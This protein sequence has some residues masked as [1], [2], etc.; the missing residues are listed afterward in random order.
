MEYTSRALAVEHLA[1]VIPGLDREAWER[2]AVHAPEWTDHDVSDPGVT[3]VEML[4]FVTESLLYRSAEPAAFPHTAESAGP[5][6]GLLD[7]IAREIALIHDEMEKLYGSQF[8]GT[9]GD[10]ATAALREIA[11][12]GVFVEEVPGGH[13]IPGVATTVEDLVDRLG[14]KLRREAF[15]VKIE[16]PDLNAGANEVPIESIELNPDGSLNT[17]YDDD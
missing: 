6:R 4:A 14:V 5:L 11:F 15:P 7:A 13:A 1:R 3:L 9:A 2:I 8:V 17:D 12:P 16:A 10:S